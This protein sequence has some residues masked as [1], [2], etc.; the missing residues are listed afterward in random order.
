MTSKIKVDTIE[1]VAGSGNVSLGSGHNLVVPGTLAI[2]G[3]STL[4]GNTTVGG[5]LGVTGVSTLTGALSAKGGAV[6]N[7]DSADVDFRVESN[8]QANMLFVDGGNDTVSFQPNSGSLT[9]KAGSNDATNN[10]RLEGGGT[11]STYLEYRGYLGH[12][13]DVN[14]TEQMRI[15]D[16]SVGGGGHTI[17]DATTTGTGFN[18]R[19]PTDGTFLEVG[20]ATGAGNGYSFVICRRN[21]TALGGISQDGT[22]GVDFDTTSDYRLKENV[23]YDFDATTR[24]KQLQPCRFNFIGEPNRTIDGFLAHEV[25]DAVPQAVKGDKDAVDENGDINPQM[26]D[27]S[28]LVPLLVKT[29]QELEA[30]ITALENAE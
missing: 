19:S 3:A 18:F 30:R 11:T 12:Q 24:L 29:I 23:T 2:T 15:T 28:K 1:N 17:G 5:T 20:H 25:T 27:Q 14:T 21:G 13:F 7:E 22:T 8:G 26:I 6:F 16:Q 10:V 9:I 4:T